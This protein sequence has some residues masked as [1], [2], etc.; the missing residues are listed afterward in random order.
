MHKLAIAAVVTATIGG[1]GL[2]VAA[3]TRGGDAHA[4]PSATAGKTAQPAG[5]HQAATATESGSSLCALTA[6]LRAPRAPSLSGMFDGAGTTTAHAAATNDCTAVG[7]HLSELEADTT[8]GPAHRPDEATCDACANNY[9]TRCET[10]GW[11]AE[12]RTCTLAASDLINAH[13]CAGASAP[14]TGNAGTIP[15][16]LS[17]ATIGQHIATTIQSAGLYADVVDLQQ[18]VSAACELGSWTLELRQCFVA[19][20]SVS[21]L[22]ACVTPP[23]P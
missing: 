20:G 21:T 19:A 12:R 3:T 9:K 1:G 23:A 2:I 14:V 18:Q 5:A 17:C 11:S 15:L 16:A 22:Q 10:E 7:R 4:K 6:A 8:H 13:L